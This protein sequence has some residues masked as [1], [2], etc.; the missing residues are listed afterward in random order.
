MPPENSL[1]GQEF[2]CSAKQNSLFRFTRE[3]TCKVLELQQKRASGIAKRVEIS[4]N[5]LIFSLFSGKSVSHRKGARNLRC[6]AA[7]PR[8]RGVHHRAGQRPDPV[9]PR[10]HTPT[11]IS[12][13]HDHDFLRRT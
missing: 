2:P 13:E 4:R 10:G 11:A 9:A 5:S 3:M 6:D 12:N 7:G 1:F 8:L